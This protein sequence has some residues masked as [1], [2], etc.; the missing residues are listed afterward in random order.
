MVRK[1]IREKILIEAPLE[2]IWRIITNHDYNVAAC[3]AS[4]EG[5]A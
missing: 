3:A 1:I 4:E 5:T 2:I